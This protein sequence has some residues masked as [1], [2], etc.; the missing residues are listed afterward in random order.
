[1]QTRTSPIAVGAVDRSRVAAAAPN[2]RTDAPPPVDLPPLVAA[3][4]PPTA[5]RIAVELE[6]DAVLRTLRDYAEAYGSLSVQETARV[7]PSVDRRALARAFTTLKS[8][9][10]KFESCTVDVAESSATAHCRGTVEF[11]RKV[12]THEPLTVPQEWLFKMRK[13]GNDWMIE[14][15]V[16]SQSSALAQDRRQS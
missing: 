1:V 12:G 5:E 6:R 15:V 14:N 13:F 4:P 2:V 16:A 11:V 3:L 9:G 10:L 7:W 8:Q